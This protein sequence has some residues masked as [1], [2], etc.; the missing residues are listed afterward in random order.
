[1]AWCQDGDAN[2]RLACGM[3]QSS[4]R[5]QR[6]DAHLADQMWAFY[7]DGTRAGRALSRQFNIPL[8]TCLRLITQGWPTRGIVALKD[9][10]AEYDR[11]KLEA[12]RV[13][14]VEKL[15]EQ[16]DEW[17]RAGKQVNRMSDFVLNNLV[18][19]MFSAGW[20]CLTEQGPDGQRRP[21]A[22]VKQVKRRRAFWEGE[23]EQRK[24]VYRVV[25]EDVP[26]SPA[27]VVRVLKDAG[28]LFVQ[29]QMVKRLWPMRSPEQRAQEGPPAGLAPYMDLTEEQLQY[30]I[31]HQ[32]EL[33]PGLRDEDVFGP[34]I[35]PGKQKN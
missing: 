20:N 29:A 27:E 3:R 2:D 19:G 26:L 33:P 25:E 30:M 6:L 28:Q 11:S 35:Q 16:T 12:E 8:W 21:R 14:Q 34:G 10:L 17:Y 22:W 4:K 15:K 5:Q 32:G 18:T 1:M 13:I 31:D 7:R 24:Q 9:R 23:G